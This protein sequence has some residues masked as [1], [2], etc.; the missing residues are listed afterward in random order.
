MAEIASPP[1]LKPS[2][3]SYSAKL[4]DDEIPTVD[5]CMLY[6][7]DPDQESLAIEHLGQVCQDYGFFY[8]VNHQIP[9][10][11]LDALFKGISEFFDPSTLEKRKV[12]S[13]KDPMDRIRWGQ[14]YS[15]GE[16]REYIKVIA[17][18]QYHFPPNPSS[19]SDILDEYYKEMR[20]VVMGLAKA[21]SKT[22]GFEESYIEKAFNLKS[23]FDVSAMNLY[24]PNYVSKSRIGIP[25]HTDPGF[26]VT[27][28][29][30]VNGG[31][32]ILSHKGYWINA[33][34]PRHAILIQLGDHLEIL[35]N[36]K[37]RSHIHRVAVDRNEVKR[38]S[39]AT[40]HGPSLDKFVSPAPEFVNEKHPQAYLG[41]TYKQSLEA[42]GSDEIDVQSSLDQIRLLKV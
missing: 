21:V 5:Y 6:S 40:L 25:D 17:H 3:E 13:K 9:E 38:I 37:Y 42:N 14:N 41:M 27:L 19:F 35:T 24:P 20:K 11:L 36:G 26:I 16:N 23:G 33:C 34:I 31:L 10:K 15:S 18:P 32:Q 2:S 22:L 8:L 1:T 39:V 29:Q 12:Y 28:V 7:N 4:V 30:D